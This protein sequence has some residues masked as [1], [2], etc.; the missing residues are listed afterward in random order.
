ML[1]QLSFRLGVW[2]SVPI[3]LYFIQKKHS[4]AVLRM[5]NA[6]TDVDED[7]AGAIVPGPV[8]VANHCSTLARF[9]PTSWINRGND[10]RSGGTANSAQ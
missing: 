10:G 2:I 6:G 1:A 5:A 4:T 8:S 7:V 9:R 3:T